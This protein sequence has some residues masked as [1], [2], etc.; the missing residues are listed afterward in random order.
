M[1]VL[2][3]LF[4]I[5][6]VIFFFF[7]PNIDI[8]TLFDTWHAVL[9]FQ[10]PRPH[11]KM[12]LCTVCEHFLLSSYYRKKNYQAISSLHRA[13]HNDVS[14]KCLLSSICRLV[15]ILFATNKI[16]WNDGTK[17]RTHKICNEYN[18]WV[19]YVFGFVFLHVS[20]CVRENGRRNVSFGLRHALAV[21]SIFDEKKNSNYEALC[22]S[23]CGEP[24]NSSAIK[25]N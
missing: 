18:C 5:F 6:S 20:K 14:S 15:F 25:L 24:Y 13:A 23:P 19:F 9:H 2:N 4:F 1:F 16:P 22:P 17:K 3:T 7:S 8:A 12:T 10:S 11:C 21:Q